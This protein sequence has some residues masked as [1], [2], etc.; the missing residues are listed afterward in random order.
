MQA[1]PTSRPRGRVPK[2][3]RTKDELAELAQ[4]LGA[5][6]RHGD[7]VMTWIR[8]HEA[9]GAELSRLVRDGWSWA[10]LG[11]A[12]ALAGIKYQT[13]PAIPGDLLRRKAGKARADE[14]NRQASEVLRRPPVAPA[15]QAPGPSGP[16]M[17]SASHLPAA[18]V[19]P[20]FSTP[21]GM[22][23]AIED[24]EPEFRPATLRGWSGTKIVRGEKKPAEA[25]APDA[26][27]P[28]NDAADVIARLLGRK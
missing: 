2:R 26:H 24:E 3:P 19:F 6:W 18:A 23:P 13:G 7:N 14:R 16:P 28:T 4:R 10:D 11:L 22:E 17:T 9:T 15:V 25:E 12:L 21:P 1:S 8:R 27:A 20:T 5:D